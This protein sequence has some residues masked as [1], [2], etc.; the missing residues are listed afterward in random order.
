MHLKANIF[1][2]KWNKTEEEIFLG[3]YFDLKANIRI[4]LNINNVII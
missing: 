2:G 4:Y 3:I 1:G